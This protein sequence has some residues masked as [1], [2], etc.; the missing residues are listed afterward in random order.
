[1]MENLTFLF[2][3]VVLVK[4]LKKFRQNIVFVG[5]KVIWYLFS[6]VFNSSPFFVRLP[7]HTFLL[8]PYGISFKVSQT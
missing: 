4:L 6:F 5:A 1:M 7:D 3:I 2:H 8:E